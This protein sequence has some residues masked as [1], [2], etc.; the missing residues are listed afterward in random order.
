[1]MES[2]P[3]LQALQ[4]SPG[5]PTAMATPPPAPENAAR[6][7]GSPA[8]T[9]VLGLLRSGDGLAAAMILHEVFEPPLSQRQ[10]R[11]KRG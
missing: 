6:P 5:L 8:L 11:G 9:R 7:T 10:R 4:P 2:L 3:Q 1:M